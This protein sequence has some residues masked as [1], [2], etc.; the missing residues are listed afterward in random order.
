MTQIRA[1]LRKQRQA[2]RIKKTRNAALAHLRM[3]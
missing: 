2:F 1:M 3:S